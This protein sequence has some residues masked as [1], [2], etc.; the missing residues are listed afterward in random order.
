M[1]NPKVPSGLQLTPL[2][3]TFREDPYPVLK[4]MREQEPVHQDSELGRYFFT[5]YD[6]VR[7]I[8]RNGEFW[9]DPHKAREGSFA[10]FLIRDDDEEVSMLLA[11]EPEHRR[12]RRY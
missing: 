3:S 9:S 8:L 1:P 12:L 7:S 2:D 5:R 4:L 11:D 6:D 10:R